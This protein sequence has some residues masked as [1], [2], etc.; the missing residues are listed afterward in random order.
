MGYIALMYFT[1]NASTHENTRTANVS[2]IY[3]TPKVRNAMIKTEIKTWRS[4]FLWLIVLTNDQDIFNQ[5]FTYEG[6]KQV[7][8]GPEK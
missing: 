1:A 3:I 2:V 6:C 7:F 4:N 5:V 8:L